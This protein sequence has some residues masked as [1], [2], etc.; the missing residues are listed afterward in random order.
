MYAIVVKATGRVIGNTVINIDLPSGIELVS[1]DDPEAL[2]PA[3]QLTEEALTRA[4]Q[5]RL[6]A[7]AVR[8]DEQCLKGVPVGELR[9]ACRETD[10][11][12]YTAAFTLSQQAIAAGLA[13]AE[14]PFVIQDV[15]LQPV[16]LTFAQLTATLLGYG[17][18][19][20]MLSTAH[21][22]ALAAVRA[23]TTTEQVA[24]VTIP[25]LV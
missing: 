22:T 10:V 11:G 24:A 20:N 12:L 6:S 21:G 8:W 17:A 18:T 19:R 7:L 16:S 4:R 9:L 14:G 1:T 2:K 25:A 13:T 15:D 23:A 3:E 5:G